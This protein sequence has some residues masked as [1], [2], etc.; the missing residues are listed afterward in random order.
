MREITE[1]PYV[2]CIGD[3]RTGTTSLHA[4]AERLGF[5]SI[6]HYEYILKDHPE[7][8]SDQRVNKLIYFVRNSPYNFFTDYPTRTYFRELY[9]S[10]PDALFINTVRSIESWK[11][12]CSNYFIR[13]GLK[14][15]IETLVESHLSVENDIRSFFKDKDNFCEVNICEDDAYTVSSVLGN[16]LLGNNK[17]DIII[18][19]ENRGVNSNFSGVE[20]GPLD[21]MRNP[22]NRSLKWKWRLLPPSKQFLLYQYTVSD[23][24]ELTFA[25]QSRGSKACLSE[26]GHAFLC[27]DSSNGFSSLVTGNHDL[28]D[29]WLDIFTKRKKALEDKGSTYSVFIIPEKVS[30][31]HDLLP[32]AFDVYGDE[33]EYNLNF[34]RIASKA[35]EQLDFVYDLRDY[36]KDIN[37]NQN[38]LFRFDSHVNFHGAYYIFQYIHETLKNTSISTTRPPSRNEWSCQIGTW[39]GDLLPHLERSELALIRHA[40]QRNSR[41]LLIGEDEVSEQ[42]L[43]YYIKEELFDIERMED[44]LLKSHHPQRPQFSFNILKSRLPRSEVPILFVHDSSIDKIYFPL[45]TLADKTYFYWNEQLMPP[46]EHVTMCSPCHVVQVIAERFLYTKTT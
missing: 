21:E 25:F 27:A 26:R 17:I 4:Y 39:N 3:S 15:D 12:S 19:C 42:F 13:A 46:E 31:A 43:H 14:V 38:L 7:A 35:Q 33:I 41:P 24:R 20:Y 22:D 45:S 28:L 5:R 40:W 6:H 8:D 32:K 10:F 18:G 29:Y 16:F 1:L 34:N 11:E 9:E 44:V 2:F 30:I 36:L 23:L 37:L